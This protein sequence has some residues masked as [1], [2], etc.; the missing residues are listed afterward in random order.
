MGFFSGWGPVQ[1]LF[2]D[3]PMQTINFGFGR[4]ALT[5][6]FKFDH[7]LGLF[8]TF[9]SPLGLFLALW[10]Y[11]WGRDQVQNTFLEPTNVDYHFL[12]WKC[13]PIF[14]FFIQPNFG[15]FCT[16]WA[17]RGYFQGWGQVQNLFLDLLTQTNNFYFGS[18]ALS[19]GF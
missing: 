16:F 9:L 19:F 14:L 18:T 6:C 11:F 12:F 15:P 2:F 5:F 8:C 7:I 1:K 10:S 13:I 3:L 17:L 4:T